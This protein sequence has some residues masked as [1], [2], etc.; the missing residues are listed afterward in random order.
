MSASA[1][2]QRQRSTVV[3]W[4]EKQGRV[5]RGVVGLYEGNDCTGGLYGD[6]GGNQ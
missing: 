1:F 3:R 4:V 6:D 2:Y 5:K